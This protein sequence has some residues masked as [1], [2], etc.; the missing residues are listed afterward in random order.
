MGRG[1]G[2]SAWWGR[3][4]MPAASAGMAELLRSA[5]PPL[6][7]YLLGLRSY[8]DADSPTLPAEAA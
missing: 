2:V 5:D 4:E 7:S 1:L 6:A 8:T 3:G